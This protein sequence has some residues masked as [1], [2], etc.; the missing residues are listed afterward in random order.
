MNEKLVLTHHCLFIYCRPVWCLCLWPLWSVK[1]NH[2]YQ[3]MAMMKKTW[4]ILHCSITDSLTSLVTD[5][6]TS[7]VTDSLTSLVTDSLTSLVTDS[8]TSLVADL[9][10]PWT[11]THTHLW[12]HG[13]GKYLI[14]LRQQWDY[15]GASTVFIKRLPIAPSRPLSSLPTPWLSLPPKD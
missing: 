2:W 14:K 13:S 6:L 9:G 7:L 11:L 12:L 4:N 15:D 5:S 8:L 1:E 3:T 10:Y